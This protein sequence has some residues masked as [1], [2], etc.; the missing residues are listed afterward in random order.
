M[1]LFLIFNTFSVYLASQC[2]Q[3]SSFIGSKSHNNINDFSLI[4]D[5]LY[6]LL[7][8][9]G[10]HQLSYIASYKW[11]KINLL[12][13]VFFCHL[14]AILFGL[15]G[16]M[17][18]LKEFALTP[19]FWHRLS[20]E[21]KIIV[22][23]IALVICTLCVIQFYRSFK[24][25][26][27]CQQLIPI[28]LLCTIWGYLWMFVKS[29]HIY[30]TIHVHHALFAG[31]FSNWFKDFHSKF[32]IIINAIFIGIV[33]EGID[34]YGIGELSLFIINQSEKVQLWPIIY[35]FF[36]CIIITMLVIT[37]YSPV[38]FV[39]R[40]ATI[41]IKHAKHI[42]DIK[43]SKLQNSNEYTFIQPII[44][45]KILPIQPPTT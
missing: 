23:V 5:M 17:P 38:S 29:E 31:L 36:I 9:L 28:F 27:C 18:Y 37:Y 1:N 30:Y 35:Q 21:G 44:N 2:L 24:K 39:R 40:G 16:E 43:C 11:K 34:F 8:V 12:I 3:M 41:L 25:Q 10:L 4:Y 42:N 33:I 6:T 19:G 15:A 32:D 45:A 13:Y 7:V 14:G 26:N 22:S 20:L